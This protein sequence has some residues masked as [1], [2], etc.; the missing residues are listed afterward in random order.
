VWYWNNS[1][2]VE[3]SLYFKATVSREKWVV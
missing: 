2:Q 3:N 1:Q